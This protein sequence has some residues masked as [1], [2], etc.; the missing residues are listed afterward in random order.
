MMNEV[1]K[2]LKIFAPEDPVLCPHS[3]CKA[4]GLV[5]RNVMDS[6]NHAATVHKIFLRV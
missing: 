6:K 3:Q 5:L 4:A 1:E 2:H